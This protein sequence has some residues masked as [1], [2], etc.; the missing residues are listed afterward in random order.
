M[1]DQHY[2]LS[3][4]LSRLHSGLYI[5]VKLRIRVTLFLFRNSPS[6][7]KS[8]RNLMRNLNRV[9]CITTSLHSPQ[10]AAGRGGGS[11]KARSRCVCVRLYD[12]G[13]LTV[14]LWLNTTMFCSHH[15]S[16]WSGNQL[17]QKRAHTHTFFTMSFEVMRRFFGLLSRLRFSVAVTLHSQY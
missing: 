11:D 9:H 12:K 15:Q 7:K 2:V 13:P 8:G 10:T 6:V 4:C 17:V 14:D 5:G 3:V 16:E 1:S